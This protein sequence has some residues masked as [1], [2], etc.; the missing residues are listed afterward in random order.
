[1]EKD[2]EEWFAQA[3]YD[4]SNALYML[5]GGR[6]FDAVFMCHLSIEKALKG[7]YQK[8]Q[9][10]FPPKVHNLVFLIEKIGLELP[11]DLYDSVFVINRVGILT[12]YPESLTK[13]DNDLDIEK[14]KEIFERNS[15]AL[16]WLKAQL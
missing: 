4:M 10:V 2:P 13:L 5:D 6:Y 1:M 9:E 3:E 12:R 16:Q 7:L 8:V 14:T 11:K 15:E